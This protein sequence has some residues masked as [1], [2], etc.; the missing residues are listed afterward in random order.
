[1]AYTAMIQLGDIICVAGGEH[2]VVTL[3]EHPLIYDGLWNLT[4][5]SEWH[6]KYGYGYDMAIYNN[7]HTEVQ[8]LGAQGYNKYFRLGMDIY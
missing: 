4:I 3:H 8:L 5:V 7:D 2:L 6:P 1:M